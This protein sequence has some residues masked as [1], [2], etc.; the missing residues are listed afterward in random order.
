VRRGRKCILKEC[1]ATLSSFENV[2]SP[3]M[4]TD[5]LPQDSQLL[6]YNISITPLKA[7]LKAH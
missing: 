1:Q 3:G 5:I 4:L 7:A 6:L 2:D